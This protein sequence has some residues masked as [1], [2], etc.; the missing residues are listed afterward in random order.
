MA[1]KISVYWLFKMDVCCGALLAVVHRPCSMRSS[2]KLSLKP[3][4]GGM[5]D[6]FLN[7]HVSYSVTRR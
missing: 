2:L 3:I 4:V 5:H 6:I 7:L 1:E